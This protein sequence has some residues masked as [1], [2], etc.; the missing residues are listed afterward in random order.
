MIVCSPNVENK[1]LNFRNQ[2]V[3][4]IRLILRLEQGF[5]NYESFFEMRKNAANN[6]Q[7][8]TPNLFF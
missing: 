6:F 3:N 5:D 4:L 2:S 1:M 8:R 7:N